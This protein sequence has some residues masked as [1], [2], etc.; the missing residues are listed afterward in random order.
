MA[1]G[2]KP[3]PPHLKIVKGTARK[4]GNSLPPLPPSRPEPPG[5]LCDCAKAEWA[6][7]APQ[8]YALRLLS[9]V[10]VAVLAAYC[11]SW[12]TFKAAS[13]AIEA[14][15]LTVETTN[16]NVIQNPLLGIA[17]KASRDM[18]RYAAEFGLTP[19]SRARL[20]VSAGPLPGDPSDRFFPGA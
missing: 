6:R 2:R 10:D 16:G 3:L 7:V 5:F 12:A 19:T 1:R 11:Q 14:A 13:E 18:V 9:E 8:L 15:G 17:N 4:R 20:Q